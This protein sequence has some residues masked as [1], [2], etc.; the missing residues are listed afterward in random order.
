MWGKER[1]RVCGVPGKYPFIFVL[2]LTVGFLAISGAFLWK[3]RSQTWDAAL[4]A[5]DNLV[6]TMAQDIGRNVAIYDLSLQAVI[7]GLR[8]PEIS[9]V[10]PSARRAILFERAAT[11]QFLGS[12]LVL[13]EHGDI[14]EDAGASPPRG[15]NLQNRAF[16][17]VHRDSA[18]V[19]LYVSEPFRRRVTA[20]GDWVIAFSRRI[21]KPDGSFGGIVSGTLRLDYF[22]AMFSRLKLGPEGTVTLFRTDGT[23]LVRWPFDDAVIG[24]N[25]MATGIVQNLL[26]APAGQFTAV[27]S[28]DG[29][30]RAI[31]FAHVAGLPL[32]VCVGQSPS[33]ILA[34]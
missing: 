23:L 34:S 15:A 30:T 13:D 22:N 27:T 3:L 29:V 31:T 6:A 1:F 9:H 26:A 2:L 7:D 19:G 11:A 10:G 18:H 12:I 14:V 28:L 21:D 4:R 24:R 8:L 25:L 32:V 16:F 17:Q 20:S 5:A 33:D